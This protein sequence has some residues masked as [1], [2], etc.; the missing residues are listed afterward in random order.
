MSTAIGTYVAC[1]EPSGLTPINLQN[2]HQGETRFYDQTNY[3][4]SAFGFSGSR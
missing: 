3:V 2:F 4:F 1:Q